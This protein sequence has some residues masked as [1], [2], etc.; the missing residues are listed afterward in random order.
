MIGSALGMG[1]VIIDSVFFD[2]RNST[3]RGVGTGVHLPRR[4]R[5]GVGIQFWRFLHLDAESFLADP[6]MNPGQ[7]E[8]QLT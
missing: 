4:D 1:F 6:A 5:E 2:L 8:T 7:Q 3:C